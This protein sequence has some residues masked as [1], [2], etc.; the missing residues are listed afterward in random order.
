MLKKIPLRIILRNKSQFLGII[1]LVFFASF[2]YALFSIMSSNIDSNYKRFI[3]EYRQETFHFITLNPI[4]IEEIS[5]KYSIDLEERLSL[6]YEFEDKT[7]R[8]FN[9]SDKINIPFIL[10]GTLPKTKEIA[11]DLNFAKENNLKIGDTIKIY[12]K[13]FRISG[14]LYLPDYTYV[15]KNEQDM[16]P[17]PKH[18]GIG[19]MDP[20]ELKEF[21]YHTPYHYYMARGAIDDINP[22]KNEINSK[23]KLLAF[24]DREDN[25][26]IIVTEKKIENI[27]PISYVISVFVLLIS[28][29]LLFIVLNRLI[30]S[31]H[32]EIGTLYALGYSQREIVTVYLMFPILIWLFGAIPGGIIGYFGANPLV[33]F[34]VSFFNI[35]LFMRVFPFKELLIAILLPAI[36]MIFSGYFA[37]RRLLNRSVLSIIRGE[38]EKDFKKRY[39]MAFL[40]RFS[41]KRRLM[42]KQGLLYPSRELVLIFGIIFATIILLYGITGGSALNNL[43]QDTYTNVLKYNYMYIFNTYQT[44]NDYQNTERFSMLSFNI[45]NTKTKVIIYG[46]EKD[47]KMVVLKGDRGEKIELTGFVITRSLADKLRLKPG[48]TINLVSIVDGRKYTLVI[49]KIADLYI[50]NSGYMNLEEFNQKFG[51]SR[52][53]FLGLYSSDSLEIPKEV[54][55]SSMD[56]KYLIKVFEDNAGSIN[57]ILQIMYV[58]SFLLSLV[59]IYVLSSITI[60]ENRKP[61]GIFKILGYYDGELSFIFLGFNYFSF[62]IGFLLGIPLFNLFTG[63]IMNAVLR[64]VDFSM[65]MKA[66]IK[67]IIITFLVLF[68]AFIFSRYLGRRRIYSIP[69]NIILKEQAE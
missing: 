37:I 55:L 29:I 9:I 27:K 24:Q 38:V 62:L 54:L 59:I 34:Y 44:K 20:T 25:F 7:I 23:Y 33:E 69:P 43:V 12:N 21:I 3:E 56:K 19:I 11:I 36:F 47:S 50:G 67:N 10:E 63:Y 57:Q 8:I 49:N 15:T 61:I 2:T 40:D 39:K 46:I 51:L 26:R 68:I 64:D 48:D 28:S 53:S 42:L 16:L 35:P 32:A 45:E 58:V 4:N 41:F 30:A 65:R 60:A 13:E 31:M 1:L 22:F 18:F 5:Q 52:N 17:D 14:Y 66:D 6:D